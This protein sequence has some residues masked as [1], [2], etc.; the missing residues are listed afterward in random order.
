MNVLEPKSSDKR[1]KS[2]LSEEVRCPFPTPFSQRLQPPSQKL[3]Q[4][5]EIFEIFKQVK[6]SIPLLDTIKQIPSYAKFLKDLCTIKRKHNVQ[7]KAFLIEQ[8]SAIIQQNSP[9]KYKDPR[10]PT[11]SCVIGNHKIESTARS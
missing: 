11:I 2:E 5:S 9:L 6:V 8:V 4:N 1:N 10:C 7:K 3:N